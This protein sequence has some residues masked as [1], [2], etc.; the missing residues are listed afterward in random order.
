MA[1]TVTIPN[2]SLKIPKILLLMAEGRRPRPRGS[3][4]GGGGDIGYQTNSNFNGRGGGRGN[5]RGFG[6]SSSGGGSGRGLGRSNNGNGNGRDGNI[7]KFSKH[8]QSNSEA[9]GTAALTKES[10]LK[11]VNILKHSNRITVGKLIQ[12]LTGHCNLNYHLNHY[13][14]FTETKC[15]KCGMGPET[16]VHLMRSCEALNQARRDIFDGGRSN[17]GNG[18]GRD[19]ES[20]STGEPAT[21]PRRTLLSLVRRIP[22]TGVMPLM[23]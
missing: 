8:P 3:G 6:R 2:Y 17:H 13:N 18:N 21:S 10:D 4:L 19:N 7:S 15:R 9:A 14:N 23:V 20:N 1:A 16:P 22:I 5:G 12:F 11:A